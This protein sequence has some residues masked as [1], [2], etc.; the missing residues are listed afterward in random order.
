MTPIEIPRTDRQHDRLL[1]ERP[2]SQG[3][4]ALLGAPIEVGARA[5]AR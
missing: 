3:R 1:R 2:A 4:I 5:A